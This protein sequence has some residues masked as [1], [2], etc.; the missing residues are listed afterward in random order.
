MKKVVLASL[1]MLAASW[2]GAQSMPLQPAAGIQGME[3]PGGEHH[4][5]P[6][7]AAACAGKAVGTQVSVTFRSGRTRSIECGVHHHHQDDSGNGPGPWA[8]TQGQ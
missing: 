1:L 2:A 4:M 3:H 6:E 7:I 8:G 5:P